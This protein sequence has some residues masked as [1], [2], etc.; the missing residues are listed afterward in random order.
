MLDVEE[1]MKNVEFKIE[2]CWS[3]YKIGLIQHDEYTRAV[4]EAFNDMRRNLGL[5]LRYYT[6][7]GAKPFP[8][9]SEAME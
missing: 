7:D 6:F 1:A 8:I 5:G 9:K 4:S 2:A 3:A